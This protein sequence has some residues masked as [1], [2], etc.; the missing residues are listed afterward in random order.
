MLS[1]V[2]RPVERAGPTIGMDL[3][4]GATKVRRVFLSGIAF[5][6]AFKPFFMLEKM[7]K[8]VARRNA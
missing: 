8:M 6:M 4:A 1:A 7:L 3:T 5:E 2:V